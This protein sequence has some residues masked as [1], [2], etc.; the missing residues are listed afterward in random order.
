MSERISQQTERMAAMTTAWARMTG[1]ML[2]GATEVNRAALEALGPPAPNGGRER[3]K[4]LPEPI[5][6]VTYRERGWTAERSVDS[7]DAISVGDTVS[8]SKRID[9]ADVSAF[10]RASGDTNRL[11]LDDEF[12]RKTRFGRRIVHGTLASGMIS[13]A[14][15][16]LPGLTIY[17]SQDVEFRHP[18][19]LGARVT[20]HAEVV[21]DLGGDRY[22]LTTVIH[23]E[24]EDR[25]A[26]E[27]EAIVLIDDLPDDRD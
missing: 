17:L 16:R 22:R 7:S 24:N 6:S 19:D 1:S 11:H 10:A 13:A 2:R 4:T 9:A 5:R 3:S 26:I 25:A 18:V 12:A 23:D 15:A 8:F 14:L 20:A 27:G 21:E